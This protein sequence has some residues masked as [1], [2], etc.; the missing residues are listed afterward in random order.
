[1]L[2]DFH[3]H[4]TYSDGTKT[5]QE[6]VNA[7]AAAGIAAIAVTDHD[8]ITGGVELIEAHDTPI[9]VIPGI[10]FSSTYHGHDVHILG[11]AFDT[12]NKR[13][14]DYIRFYKEERRTR[15]LKMVERCHE[16]GYDVSVAEFNK[17]Y[18]TEGSFGRPH[19][20]RML[21]AKG[22][23]SSVS[24]AFNTILSPKSP[25]YVQKFNAHP[26]DI[27]DIIHEAGG[28]CIMAH[29]VLI[30]T[31]KDVNELLQLPFDGMEVYHSKQD[32][33]TSAQYRMMAKERGMLMS[34]GS[35][36]HG[37]EGQPPLALGDFKIY[38]DRVADFMKAV[39]LGRLL[40]Q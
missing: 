9:P 35:D 21:I 10:E 37:I 15:L 16:A 13:M 27:V 6:L 5:P 28:I 20:A 29:P 3:M 18:G 32:D 7:A 23:T 25:C 40:T 24:E 12:K 30:H 33:A 17:L 4:S 39:G 19:L 1:M 31:A 8:E 36:Y 26:A 38:A 34:G 11:Y 2:V 14:V 22:Y